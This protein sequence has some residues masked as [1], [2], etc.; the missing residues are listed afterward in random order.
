MQDLQKI[1]AGHDQMKRLC[2]AANA[3]QKEDKSK[4]KSGQMLYDA[5][6]RAVKLRL[7]EFETFK[8]QQG[9]LLHLCQRIHPPIKGKYMHISKIL[10]MLNMYTY[11]Y[12]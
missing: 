6:S 3:K 12:F 8:E 10:F 7:G 1:Q 2:E 11:R 5:L 4:Q 9:F